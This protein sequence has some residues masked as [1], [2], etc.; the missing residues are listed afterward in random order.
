LERAGSLSS[1]S[2]GNGETNLPFLITNAG[3]GVFKMSWVVLRCSLCGG[4]AG[5]VS[6]EIRP[7]KLLAPVF[8]ALIGQ[9]PS[10]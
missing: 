8:L 4:G 2:L 7:E 3:F 9:P 10:V 5:L 1:P 6:T